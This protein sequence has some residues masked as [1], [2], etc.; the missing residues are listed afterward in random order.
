MKL[1][2]KKLLFSFY[3]Q[4]ELRSLKEI[5]KYPF[6]KIKRKTNVLPD[7]HLYKKRRIRNMQKKH[8][9]QV[10]IETG[11]FYGQMVKSVIPYFDKVISIEIF[12]PLFLLNKKAFKS[13]KNVSLYLGDSSIVLNSI[14]NN[15][16]KSVLYWLDGHYSGEGTGLGNIVS[17]ILN[18]IEIIM[19]K[20]IEKYC[21]IIDDLRL[22]TNED[23]YPSEESVINIVKQKNPNITIF[24]DNDALILLSV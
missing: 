10:F 20:N 15:D 4:R 12:E 14:L 22:F 16:M 9:F 23:G 2:I 13:N 5:L 18:E 6:W 1:N 21:I 24:K 8:N 7:N 3:L 11:T 19:S 17:P